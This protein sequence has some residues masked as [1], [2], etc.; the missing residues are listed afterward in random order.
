LG[1]TSSKRTPQLLL[2][3]SLPPPSSPADLSYTMEILLAF[4]PFFACL[5]PLLTVDAA[6]F[7]TRAI[8]NALPPYIAANLGI[9]SPYKAQGDYPAVPAGCRINQVCPFLLPPFR[10]IAP[11][12]AD[13][14][15]DRST[16]S[17]VTASGSRRP[18]LEL[19]FKLPSLS[20]KMRLPSPTTWPSSARTTT[21]WAS[22]TLLPA[23][24]VSCTPL[25]D[26]T[27]SG[28]R[29]SGPPSLGR[30]ASRGLS[31]R[32][33]TGQRVSLRRVGPVRRCRCR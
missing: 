18:A 9:Y 6:P 29:V 32:Q 17:N 7:D 4:L 25:D 31:T 1:A 10:L 30:T 11:I 15:L 3:A 5:L 19:A 24:R 20:C 21:P 13:I 2:R 8:T 23:V 26:S 12:N 33:R 14:T 16:S 28:M 22:M 27:T